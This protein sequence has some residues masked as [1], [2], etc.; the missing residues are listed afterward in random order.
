MAADPN[1][2]DAII[3]VFVGKGGRKS[4]TQQLIWLTATVEY[5]KWAAEIGVILDYS[6]HTT[7]H[8]TDKTAEPWLSM[9]N[10]RILSAGDPSM[11]WSAG[12]MS[13][14]F[15]ARFTAWNCVMAKNG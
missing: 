6:E 10:A 4:C 9:R 11:G 7:M 13:L 8:S 12:N 1:S 5:D 14:N 3:I 15:L 2:T